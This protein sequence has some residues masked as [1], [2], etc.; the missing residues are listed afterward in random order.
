MG[1][2][3]SYHSPNAA[4]IGSMYDEGIDTNDVAVPD[5]TPA[6]SVAAVVPIVSE[7][8]SA[9]YRPASNLATPTEHVSH[10]VNSLFTYVPNSPPLVTPGGSTSSQTTTSVSPLHSFS[11]SLLSP[12][13][14]SMATSVSPSLIASHPY[15]QQNNPNLGH[16]FGAYSEREI[17]ILHNKH[18]LHLIRDEGLSFF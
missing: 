3:N 7:K 16:P 11:S 15:P 2:E 10:S 6:V 8:F 14:P 12:T 1:D 13:S 5:S 4:A 17:N 9:V 18:C